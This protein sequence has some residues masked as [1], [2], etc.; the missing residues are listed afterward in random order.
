L[1]ASRSEEVLAAAWAEIDFDA[2]LWTVPP[3]RMKAGIQHVV[4]LG[5]AALAVLR[6]MAEIRE[7]DFIFSGRSGHGGI[8]IGADRDPDETGIRVGKSSL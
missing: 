8:P 3:E 6:R 7:N 5:D 4:P 1:T 2:Q